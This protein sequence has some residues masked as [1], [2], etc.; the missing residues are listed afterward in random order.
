VNARRELTTAALLCAVGAG[1]ALL[2]GGRSWATVRARDAITPLSQHVTGHELTAA[3]VAF[4]WAGLAG[5]AALFATRGWG[6]AAVGALLASLGAGIVYAST[7]AV[8]HAHVL[9]VAGDKSPL[10]RVGG[11]T[12]VHIT[13]WWTVS[14]AGGVL[15]C[16]GGLMTLVRGSR[17]PGMSARYDRAPAAEGAAA[18]SRTGA[19]SAARDAQEDPSALWKSLDRGEDPTEIPDTRD[20]A[21]NLSRPG[22]RHGAGGP[23]G[24][25]DGDDGDKRDDKER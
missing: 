3:A 22:K 4:G 14:A 10:M 15:L 7:T 16:L 23:G 25:G 18:D 2:A 13:A 19:V 8:R 5:L 21:A 9:Q 6:R 20:D 17:W 12:A 11:D 1:S 24:P